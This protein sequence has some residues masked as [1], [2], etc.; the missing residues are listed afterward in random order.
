LEA[1]TAHTE[2]YEEEIRIALVCEDD[3]ESRTAAGAA[4]EA[5]T[6]TVEFPSNTDDT[7]QRLKSD[8]YSVVVLDERFGQSTPENNAVYKFFQF[9][10]MS[11]RRYIFLAMTGKNFKTSDNMTA[12]AKS[13]NV[14]V[15]EKD[16]PNLR[17]ILKKSIAENEQ[18]YKV[19]K[20][21]LSKAGKK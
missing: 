19:F 11:R 7:L 4:L 14:V 5:L 3:P 21:C 2:E 9:M 8:E 10:P 20:Q 15:N 12:L 6:Y 13:V 1:K 17:T 16:I 18:F